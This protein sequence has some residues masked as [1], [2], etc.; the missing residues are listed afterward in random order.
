MLV[1]L[2]IPAVAGAATPP[3]SIVFARAV[4]GDAIYL[5]W[6]PLNGADTDTIYRVYRSTDASTYSQVATAT[7]Q[8]RFSY[9][10]AGLSS[11][12]S[13]WYAVSAEDSR[14]VGIRSSA[15]SATTLGPER[16][17]GL[18]ITNTSTGALLSWT[19]P[20]NPAVV[21]YYIYR[22]DSSLSDMTTLT[23]APWAS[24]SFLNSG[25]TDGRPY[26]YRVAAVDASGVV[27]AMSIEARAYPH[28]LGTESLSPHG[29]VANPT[30]DCAACHRGHVGIAANLGVFAEPATIPASPFAGPARATA[31]SQEVC[32]TCHTGSIGSNVRTAVE[33]TGSASLHIITPSYTSAPLW[34]GHCHESHRAQDATTTM[35]LDVD[36]AHSGDAVCFN[37]CHGPASSLPTGDFSAFEGS[38][39]ATVTS[40]SAVDVVCTACHDVHSSP[41]ADLLYYSRWMVCMQCHGV[42]GTASN[43]DQLTIMATGADNTARHDVTSE[44]QLR[45]GARMSCVNCHNSH[46]NT[47]SRP[48]IDPES[49]S[50]RTTSR[51]TASLNAFCLVCHDGTLPTAAQTQPWVASPLAASGATRTVDIKSAYTVNF[52]GSATSTD[53][54]MFLNTQMGYSAGDTLQC[55]ACHG[56]HGALNPMQLR[57]DVRSAGGTATVDRA[58]VATVPGG[59]YDLR[60]FCT[61]CHNL[62]PEAHLA[63][64]ATV[65]ISTFPMDC[66]GTGC[67]QHT[68]QPAGSLTPTDTQ[69]AF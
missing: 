57:G 64:T 54:P 1:V 45:S 16:P 46:V 65:D 38:A 22:A 30:D 8:F 6:Q 20:S 29:T 19:A 24:T 9:I 68:V 44:D 50:N 36:G 58:L 17:T 52:H 23:V 32:L 33:A 28:S 18:T 53:G 15:T 3:P 56:E 69:T 61:A 41:N 49:P 11:S 43:P 66:T 14:G 7:G 25:L 60:F 2:L 5:N 40:P 10:D 34:C 47:A 62:T 59:G 67:H 35:M 27:G 51:W 21:G 48:L 31:A 37:G 55:S 42:R 26:W 39:H 4:D 13:Y 63:A 12:T